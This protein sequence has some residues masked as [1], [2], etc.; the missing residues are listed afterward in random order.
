MVRSVRN[1][2]V[3]PVFSDH[4]EGG[5]GLTAFVALLVN[6]PVAFNGHLQ[7]CRDRVDG[8]YTNAVKAA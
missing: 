5:R 2:I 3:V 6:R 1:R 4:A 7:P 8:R